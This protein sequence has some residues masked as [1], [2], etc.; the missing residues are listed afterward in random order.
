MAYRV[1]VLHRLKAFNFQR[2]NSPIPLIAIRIQAL[3]RNSNNPPLPPTRGIIYQ[4][5]SSNL[6]CTQRVFQFLQDN[7]KFHGFTTRT[8]L[9]TDHFKLRQSSILSSKLRHN[10]NKLQNEF[11]TE[12][13]GNIN[14][15]TR[16]KLLNYRLRS[17]NLQLA[18]RGTLPS[19]TY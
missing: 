10:H 7:R 5:H 4:Q 8:N 17:S 1:I 11:Y 9:P 12:F 15:P 13:Q 2:E 6:S 14:L 18:H 19:N 3:P 16:T